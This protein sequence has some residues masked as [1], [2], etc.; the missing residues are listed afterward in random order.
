MIKLLLILLAMVIMFAVGEYAYNPK[1]STTS[2]T[3]N[4]ASQDQNAAINNAQNEIN[5][6]NQLQKDTGN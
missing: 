5:K 2:S 6:V 1:S 4:S 3:S